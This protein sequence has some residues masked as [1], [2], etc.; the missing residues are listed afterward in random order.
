M[1]VTSVVSAGDGGF[2]ITV[3]DLIGN[4]LWIPTKLKER[5]ENMFISEALLRNGGANSNGLVGYS[6]GDP[7]FLIG[8]VEDVAEFGEIP[9]SSGQ[10]GAPQIAVATKRGLGVRVSRE[11]RDENNVRAVTTQMTQL[12][13]TFIRADD[14]VAKALLQSAAVPTLAAGALWNT[15]S[16][17]PRLD[18]ANAIE[19][20]ATAAPAAVDGGSA[21][22]WYGFQP[23]T[24][25]LNGGILPTLISNDKFNKIFVGNI[26]NESITYT[27]AY[28]G[29]IFGLDIIRSRSFPVNK[30]LILERGTI[31]F[32][33]DTRPREITGLYPEGNGPNGGPSESW[34]CDATHKRAIALDQPKAGIWLTGVMP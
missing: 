32:Y 3:A 29:S 24:L 2:R 8:D 19:S 11:M 7:T 30:V 26:A 33:S 34:R 6:Q 20:I 12:V 18:I 5:M 10:Q 21:E 13:N 25:V 23:D 14:R 1:P 17:D 31:G 28:P 16:G 4:P 15:A 22:E 9:V 27:G